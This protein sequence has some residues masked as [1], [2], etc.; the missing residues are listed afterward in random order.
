MKELNNMKIINDPLEEKDVQENKEKGKYQKIKN[1][2]PLNNSTIEVHGD[3]IPKDS[4]RYKE[5]IKKLRKYYY[6]I[7]AY[8]LLYVLYLKSLEKCFDGEDGCSFKFKWIMARVK[9]GIISCILI[10]IMT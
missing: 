8:F 5:R 2:E 7:L 1:D 10:V 3:K 9:E 6:F 4:K